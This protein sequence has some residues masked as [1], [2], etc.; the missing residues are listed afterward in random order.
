MGDDQDGFSIYNELDRH[1]SHGHDVTDIW[2]GTERPVQPGI[3]SIILGLSNRR[4]I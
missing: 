4:R 1:C 3:E 2:T